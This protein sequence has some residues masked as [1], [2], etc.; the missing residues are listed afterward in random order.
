[1]KSVFVNNLPWSVTDVEFNDFLKTNVTG[2]IGNV[3]ESATVIYGS[4]HRSRGYAI[5]KCVNSKGSV[6][7][8]QLLNGFNYNGRML[9]VRYDVGKKD[10]SRKFKPPF[11]LISHLKKK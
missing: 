9:E 3:I 1:M 8:I 6:K 7:L 10:Q 11:N 2:R 5:I 4:D